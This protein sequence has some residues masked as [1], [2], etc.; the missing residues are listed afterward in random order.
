MHAWGKQSLTARG[1]RALLELARGI[2]S[3]VVDHEK[4]DADPWLFGVANGVID[5]KTG[6]VRSAEP[7]DLMTMQSPVAFDPDA[8]APRWEQALAEWFPDAEVRE[9]VQRLAGGALVGRQRDRRARVHPRA[10]IWTG[11]CCELGSPLWQDMMRLLL[12]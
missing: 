6:T 10:S 3:I 5:L 11:T 7:A 9:Y 12:E 4:L 2:D 8:K 1:I